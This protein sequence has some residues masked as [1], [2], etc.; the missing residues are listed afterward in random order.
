MDLRDR[1]E[2]IRSP[3]APT[4][5]RRQRSI[6]QEVARLLREAE[7]AATQLLSQHLKC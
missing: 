7:V 4:P 1:A 3:A 6:D 5:K 2:T